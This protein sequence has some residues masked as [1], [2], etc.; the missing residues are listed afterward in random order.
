M[1]RKCILCGSEYKYCPSCKKDA[2]KEP[3]HKL[4]DNA[5]CRNISKALTDYNLGKITKEDAR[6]TL[7]KCDLSIKL[8]DHYRSEINAIMAKP[9]KMARPKVEVEI[10]EEA[11]VVIEEQPVI[12]AVQPIVEEAKEE[13]IGVVLTE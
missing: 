5:N 4:Y 9:K 3:W 13:P 12:E 10:V 1:A 2:K 7:S 8:N 11:P 6:E